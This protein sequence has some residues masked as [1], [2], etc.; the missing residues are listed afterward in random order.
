VF[1]KLPGDEII[2][3]ESSRMLR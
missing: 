2:V 1:L 3:E